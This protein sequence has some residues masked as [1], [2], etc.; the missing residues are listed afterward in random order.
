MK[1]ALRINL[2]SFAL[3]IIS[4]TVFSQEKDS[5]VLKELV[6]T[7]HFVFTAQTVL[8]LG[9]AMRQLTS[10]YDVKLSGDSLITYLPYFGRAYGPINPGDD[11]GIK[12]T[13]T[14]FDYNTK[15]RKKGGWDITITPKD[16][17][18]VRQLNFT[19]S[20]SG[21]ATLQVS[22]NNRQSISYNGYISK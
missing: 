5:K 22:S 16:N 9:G 14:K 1:S 21:Y 17:R 2:I 10:E 19:I 13:S 12:F 6:E 11:G 7:K 15:A 8:P 3:L 18:D 20:T 4:V